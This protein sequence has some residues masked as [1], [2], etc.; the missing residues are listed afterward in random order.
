MGSDASGA[1]ARE[2]QARPPAGVLDTLDDAELRAL[3]EMIHAARR[4]QSAALRAAGDEALGHLPRLVRGAIKR[5][6]GA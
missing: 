5:V 2:L 4:R 6:A 3:T 1:L